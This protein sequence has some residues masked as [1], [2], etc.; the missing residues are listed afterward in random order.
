MDGIRV[1]A[2]A[3][4]PRYQINIL[5]GEEGSPVT[6]LDGTENREF[7]RDWSGDS[8]VGEKPS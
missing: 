8:S 1:A 3:A 2:H 5:R 4:V 7:I 6:G